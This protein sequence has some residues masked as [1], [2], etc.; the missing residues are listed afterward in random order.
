MKQAVVIV[1]WSGGKQQLDLLLY[2]LRSYRKYPFYIVYNDITNAPV[3]QIV[4][5]QRDYHL[6]AVRGDHYECGAIQAILD[7]TDIDEFIIMQDTFEVISPIWIDQMFEAFPNQSV[8]MGPEFPYFLG[9]YRREVLLKVEIPNTTNKFE[10]IAAEGAFNHTYMAADGNMGILDP[11]FIP[12]ISDDRLEM[13]WG[14]ANL[15][16][17]NRYVIKRQGTWMER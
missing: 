5:L 17:K 4:D 16:T 10:S 15:V 11:E 12:V 2:S 14:R 1:T 9:K 7:G 8:A 3:N 13:R 6:L